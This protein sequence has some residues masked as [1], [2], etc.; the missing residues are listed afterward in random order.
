[1]SCR[2]KAYFALKLAGDSPDAPHMARARQ[3]ILAAAAPRAPTSSPAS[4][5]RSR[6]VPWRGVP[7][8]PV[9]IMLLPRW[10]PFHLDK[11]SYWSRTV[12]VPLFILCTLQAARAQSAPAC[13]RELFSTPPKEERRYFGAGE[14]RRLV[15]KMFLLIDRCA[16]Q[17]DP[18][19]PAAMRR[20]PPGG[21]KPGSSSA[22]RRG[23]ARRHFPRDGE[24]PRGHGAAG[25]S[26]RRPAAPH[27]QARAAEA[28]G[29][30]RCRHLLPALRVAR[31]GHRPGRA[32]MQEGAATP[33]RHAS[34]A[35]PARGP[36]PRLARAAAAA[37]GAR[38]LAACRARAS[39]A[40]AGPSSSRT[41]IYPDLD[42]TAVIVW[43]MH[44]A[45]SHA[46]RCPAIERALDWLVGMQSRNGGFGAFDVD[47]A[48]SGSTRFPSPITA[49]CS[50]RPP[51]TSPR[52]W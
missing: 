43:A 7:Y 8:I 4:P 21:P 1:M 2:V 18:F 10:F 52:A 11:V 20:P 31:L 46:A 50:I 42:D 23:R 48:H 34:R 17:I 19:I 40:A 5:S 28:A 32:R 39:R 44:R 41:P 16:R 13:L 14:A 47:N 25:L 9:E 24:C 6:E 15:A 38:R 27:R 22:E 12:M 35:E 29:R 26:R 37:R 51:A 49:R 3:A 33:R 45:P 36:R 30:D